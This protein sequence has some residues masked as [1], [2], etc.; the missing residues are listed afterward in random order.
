M[1][2]IRIIEGSK[3]LFV[4][5]P[6]KLKDGTYRDIVHPVNAETR[7][8]IERTILAEYKKWSR[9]IHDHFGGVIAIGFAAYFSSKS[10]QFNS[11]RRSVLAGS[12]P[13]FSPTWSYHA[14]AAFHALSGV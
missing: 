12:A 13:W 6:S 4:A 8:T 5:M 1:H 9:E 14:F 10:C 2:D 3:G 11:L 7:E